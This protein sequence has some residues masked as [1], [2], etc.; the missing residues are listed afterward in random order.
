M[1]KSIYS[2]QSLIDGDKKPTDDEY[3]IRQVHVK[4]ILRINPDY[5]VIMWNEEGVALEDTEELYDKQG[6]PIDMPELKNGKWK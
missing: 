1:F 6:N 4:H 2:R 3:S 5:D